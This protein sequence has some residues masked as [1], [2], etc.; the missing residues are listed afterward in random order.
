MKTTKIPPGTKISFTPAQL[1]VLEKAL[2]VYGRLRLGQFSTALDTAFSGQIS[3]ENR[4]IIHKTARAFAIN[5]KGESIFPFVSPDCSF[6]VGQKEIGDGQLAYE[7]GQT[8][9]QYLAVTEN[10]GYWKSSHTGFHDALF[11]SGEPKI[12]I[13]GFKDY[14]DFEV[15]SPLIYKFVILYKDKE[16]ERLWKLVKDNMNLPKCEKMQV[17]ER[18]DGFFDWTGI[19]CFRPEKEQKIVVESDPA[20]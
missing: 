3:Y 9:R 7:V 14:I 20:K 8:V 19:R 12:N 13:E 4:D 6:G 16:W 15:K 10:D 18:N 17:V 2:E 1:K 11:Y 5:Y